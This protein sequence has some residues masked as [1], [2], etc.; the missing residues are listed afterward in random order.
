[1][2]SSFKSLPQALVFGVLLVAQVTQAAPLPQNDALTFLEARGGGQSKAVTA[3]CDVAGALALAN[4]KNPITNSLFWTG[5]GIPAVDQ[6]A[7]KFGKK[8]LRHIWDDAARS[9]I[10]AACVAVKGPNYFEPLSKAFATLAAGEVWV[11]VADD[12]FK[13]AGLPTDDEF[14]NM[15]VALL[16]SRPA[17]T[18][19]FMVNAKG[20][21]K[22][23][24]K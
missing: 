10:Q 6:V 11:F 16:K 7:A 20:E 3:T 13:A 18:S 23:I 4:T 12:K 8:Q 2:F 15:E 21:K 19:I 22:K 1:M 5:V 14:L 9:A 17:V 24:P